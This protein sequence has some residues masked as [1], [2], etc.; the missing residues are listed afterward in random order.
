MMVSL[1]V[2]RISL[3][4]RGMTPELR[5]IKEMTL[6]TKNVK[7]GDVRLKVA[8]PMMKGILSKSILTANQLVIPPTIHG[9]K[10]LSFKPRWEKR[11][12]WKECLN[13]HENSMGLKF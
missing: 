13:I 6:S 10:N 5:K 4:W 2:S 7:G 3:N 8:N 11:W 12:Q 1:T 9:E